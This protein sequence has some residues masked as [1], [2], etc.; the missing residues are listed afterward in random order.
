M[1]QE[2]DR[3]QENQ[4]PVSVLEERKYKCRKFI[5]II[6]CMTAIPI[7]TPPSNNDFASKMPS[8]LPM[9]PALTA[10]FVEHDFSFSGKVGQHELGT[11]SLLKMLLQSAGPLIPQHSNSDWMRDQA[12]WDSTFVGNSSKVLLNCFSKMPWSSACFKYPA[13]PIPISVRK[14]IIKR[15]ENWKYML[16]KIEKNLVENYYFKKLTVKIMHE[17]SLTA[18]QH[19]KNEIEKIMPPTTINTIGAVQKFSPEIQKRNLNQM[20]FWENFVL[21]S[22]Q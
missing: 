7:P 19:P 4:F 21:Q 18:P 12:C 1:F 2:Y 20:L 16:F 8:N 22:F 14:I 6:T 15:I 10:Y 17:L 13:I 5:L 9:H 11:V 3:Q